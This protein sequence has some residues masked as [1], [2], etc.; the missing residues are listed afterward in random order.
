VTAQHWL[1]GLGTF[2]TLVLLAVA[3]FKGADDPYE[4]AEEYNRDPDDG[5]IP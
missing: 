4:D 1:I 3:L 2:W 5:W